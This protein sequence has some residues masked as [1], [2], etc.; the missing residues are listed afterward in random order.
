M[1]ES[2]S[3]DDWIPPDDQLEQYAEYLRGDSQ[4]TTQNSDGQ[5]HGHVANT[6]GRVDPTTV[7]RSNNPGANRGYQIPD[8]YPARRRIDF[9][10]SRE[11]A[12][13]ANRS[14][15]IP[16]DEVQATPRSG[17][18]IRFTSEEMDEVYHIILQYEKKASL[19]RLLANRK[20]LEV[21]IK[22]PRTPT[23][24]ILV[25]TRLAVVKTMVYY[26]ILRAEILKD[27]PHK[28]LMMRYLKHRI[29]E[30]HAICCTSRS[31]EERSDLTKTHKVL[32]DQHL[33]ERVNQFF[34]WMG[35]YPSI[36][37][38]ENITRLEIDL[39]TYIFEYELDL[40]GQDSKGTKR[41]H[42]DWISDESDSDE[43]MVTIQRSL[44]EQILCG[45][46][47]N[48]FPGRF[49]LAKG[50]S[51]S[52]YPPGYFDYMIDTQ[53]IPPNMTFPAYFESM[54]KKRFEPFT[55]DHKTGMSY[56]A[57]FEKFRVTV[58][59]KREDKVPIEVKFITFKSL[60]KKGSVA[61][62]ML[63]IYKN[64]TDMHRAYDECMRQFWAEFGTN[65]RQT[66]LK[67]QAALSS[68]KPKGKSSQ[69]QLEF[70]HEVIGHFNLLLQC[71]VK[72]RSAVKM[73]KHIF[74]NLDKR[75]TNLFA[76]HKGIGLDG[77]DDYYLDNPRKHLMEIPSTLRKIF[78][79]IPESVDEDI[80]MTAKATEIKEEGSKDHLLAKAT[81]AF[82]KDSPPKADFAC[83]FCGSKA[84]ISYLCTFSIS[85]R[86]EII[87]DKGLCFNCLRKSCPG[88]NHCERDSFCKPCASTDPNRPK[89]SSWICNYPDNPYA[90]AVQT[91]TKPKEEKKPE[92][93]KENQDVPRKEEKKPATRFF[94]PKGKEYSQA[95]VAKIAAALA[96]LQEATE[97]PPEELESEVMDCEEN[98]PGNG[99]TAPTS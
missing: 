99:E 92:I 66:L 10:A 86:R 31:E 93:K 42:D 7:F 15:I 73:C 47:Q 79:K 34:N 74:D 27:G 30:V 24:L 63:L 77:T 9:M 88:V 36:L 13:G 80:C 67:L 19:K 60:M 56:P 58:H 39:P 6:Y 54:V 85:K 55:G 14:R 57:F 82:K 81:G 70:V 16:A 35:A 91:V 25:R 52:E 76:L 37:T 50:R 33:N 65:N 98:V 21:E 61:E 69:Q 45:N 59:L 4:D 22:N 97:S 87:K 41:R 20:T 84:H 78:E 17:E 29:Q 3:L 44:H 12:P 46:S 5:N 90:R 83:I 26:S 89:H 68:I 95:Q 96:S 28:S 75:I 23:P 38:K 62:S 64:R 1:S 72:D 53:E 94:R 43:E 48:I 49:T 18:D 40:K 71:G 8:S 2:S 51:A 32:F 11:E